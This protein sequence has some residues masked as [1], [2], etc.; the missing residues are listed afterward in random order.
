MP[1]L[2]KRR[3]HTTHWWRNH[4]SQF[5]GWF[6]IYCCN[7]LYAR[8]LCTLKAQIC[9]LLQKLEKKCSLYGSEQI[10]AC[11]FLLKPI[12]IWPH[13]SKGD[14]YEEEMEL[15]LLCYVS[16]KD[17]NGLNQNFEQHH[18]TVNL[19]NLWKYAKSADWI[20]PEKVHQLLKVNPKS[21]QGETSLP[22]QVEAPTQIF[23][24]SDFP[25]PRYV[26]SD[27]PDTNCLWSDFS[28][29]RR[30]DQTIFRTWSRL[31]FRPLPI[32]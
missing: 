16:D 21:Q 11:S 3:N 15:K 9:S 7:R 31:K 24:W 26:W 22:S 19:L 23:V 20:N 32:P 25:D 29:R 17:D 10:N 8:N 2:K 1:S 14:Y 18:V 27:S 13:I 4:F 5:W 28:D 6:C 30:S 12:V